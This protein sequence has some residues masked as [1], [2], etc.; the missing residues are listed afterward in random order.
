MKDIAFAHE[1]GWW[2]DYLVQRPPAISDSDRRRSAFPPE[3]ARF[4]DEMQVHAARRIKLLEVG[5]GPVSLLAWGVDQGL[6][7]MIAVDPLAE[8]YRKMLTKYGLQYPV[9]PME[10]HG[11][12]LTEMFAEGTFDVVYSSNALDHAIAPEQC[13][14]EI[15]SVVRDGGIVYLEGYC[16][17]GSNEDWI[18]LHQ[19]DLVPEDGHLVH[20]DREGVRTNLTAALQLKCV[21]Q[22]VVPFSERGID[23]FGYEWEE[24]GA[25]MNWYYADWYTM[26]FQ[27]IA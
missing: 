9:V 5:S 25:V 2:D 27:R 24:N 15:Y 26:A 21:Y 18:G 22:R 7:D 1:I 3:L 16:H 12:K 6:F 10:G 23:T 19:H 11:E 4:V 13:L 8:H 14:R 17:E 20:F